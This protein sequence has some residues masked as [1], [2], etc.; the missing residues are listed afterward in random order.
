MGTNVPKVAPLHILHSSSA[1]SNFG[2]KRGILNEGTRLNNTMNSYW[3]KE[4]KT[5]AGDW[6]LEVKRGVVPIGNIR[7]NKLLAATRM[8]S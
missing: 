2:G 7:K 6:A 8:P 1:G 5:L 3:Y 4:Y